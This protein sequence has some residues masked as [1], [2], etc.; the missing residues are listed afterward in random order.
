M[1]AT[2]IMANLSQIPVKVLCDSGATHN[3]IA[4]LNLDLDPEMK[5][6][7]GLHM[8]LL[9]KYTKAIPHLQFPSP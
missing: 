6:H 7:N 8:N 9:E 3:I 5:M 4:S 2:F 1:I